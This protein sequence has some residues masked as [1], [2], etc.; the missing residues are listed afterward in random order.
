MLR[1]VKSDLDKLSINLLGY[2]KFWERMIERL[3][4][5]SF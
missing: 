4:N 2:K 3:A 5:S 1:K